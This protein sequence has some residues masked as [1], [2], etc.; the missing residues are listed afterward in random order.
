MD[1]LCERA[2]KKPKEMFEELGL[3]TDEAVGASLDNDKTSKL[4][5]GEIWRQ[6]IKWMFSK[7][8]VHLL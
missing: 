3:E 8:L 5:R 2:E 4:K 7:D 6:K 1:D